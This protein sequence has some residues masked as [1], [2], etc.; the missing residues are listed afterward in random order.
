MAIVKE[1]LSGN[2]TFF[3]ASDLYGEEF[4]KKL[5]AEVEK[6]QAVRIV[7]DSLSQLRLLV[8]DP[9]RYRYAMLRLKEFFMQRKSTV[10]ILN[11]KSP[12]SKDDLQLDG[13][14]HGTIILENVG[15]DFGA[16]H[17]RLRIGKLRGSQFRRGYHNYVIEPGGIMLFP[18]LATIER[19]KPATH[20]RCSTGISELDA[21]LGGGLDRGT[22]NLL[23]GPTGTGK[24]TFA[25]RFAYEA[26]KRGEKTRIFTHS[27]RA[28]TRWSRA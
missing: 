28:R 10:L 16:E 19:A 8:N 3:D 15:S 20:E 12:F 4:V 21:L 22:S 27:R 5:Q 14:V 9:L 17:R 6:S 1:Q 11:D 23:N 7:F 13:I 26:A 25:L 2:Q 24:T 18:R